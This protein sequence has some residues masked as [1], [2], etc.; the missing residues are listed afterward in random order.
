M[1]GQT[2][3]VRGSRLGAMV[4][5]WLFAAGVVTQVFLAGLALFDSALRWEDHRDFG[6]MIGVLLLPLVLLVLVGRL[7]RQVIGMTVAL[8]A[9]Y[10]VQISLPGLDASYIAA[11]HPLVGF[12]LVG[13]PVQL[14]ARIRQIAMSEGRERHASMGDER[15][16]ITS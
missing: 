1:N 16:A 14:G 6:M 2:P 15:G 9:L 3:L 11:I 13:L 7:P 5:A 12:A 4:L 10:G 8:M